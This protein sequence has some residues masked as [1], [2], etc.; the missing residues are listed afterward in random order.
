[1]TNQLASLARRDYFYLDAFWRVNRGM[2]MINKVTEQVLKS[3][4]DPSY[5]AQNYKQIINYHYKSVGS[6]RTKCGFNHSL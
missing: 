6:I 5:F 3:D 1:M 4:R 2:Y